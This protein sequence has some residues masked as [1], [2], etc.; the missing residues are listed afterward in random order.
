MQAR[1]ITVRNVSAELAEK[2]RSLAKSR[3][4]SI[5]STV[6]AILRQALEVNERRQRLARYAT[7]TQDD[8]SEFEA[9]LQA[10][11]GIDESLWK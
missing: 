9:A 2:L 8:L 1:Q 5:N 3:G 11:R 7:W 10:Q 4:E 6:L